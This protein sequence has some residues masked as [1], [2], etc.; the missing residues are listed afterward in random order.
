[1][2]VFPPFLLTVNIHIPVQGPVFIQQCL[3]LKS[4]KLE[5]STYFANWIHLSPTVP[6]SF[7]QDRIQYNYKDITI[8]ATELLCDISCYCT[9]MYLHTCTSFLHSSHTPPYT[10]YLHNGIIHIEGIVHV[11]INQPQG[12][13]K[14][15][16]SKL[17]LT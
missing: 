12:I 5:F 8:Y 2:N 4:A 11:S 13:N 6:T 7:L 16:H 15:N 17:L 10:Y 14:Y 3:I 1:M 9:Y